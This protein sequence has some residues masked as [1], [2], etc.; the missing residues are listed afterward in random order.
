MIKWSEKLASNTSKPTELTEALIKYSKKLEKQGF[1]VIFDLAHLA[2]ILGIEKLTLASI[3]N[4]SSKFYRSFKIPK[5]RHNTFREI[6]SPYP[7]L[8]K[9][10]DWIKV[11]ILEK[12]EMSHHC[13]SYRKNVSI[14]DNAS[15]HLG[16]EVL[17]KLDLVDFFDNIKED[18]ILS[19]FLNCG[20]SYKVSY[21]LTS[22]CLLTT[23]LPQGAST[24][25]IISNIIAKRLDKRLS[26]LC[27]KY[28]INYS[29]YSDDITISGKFVPP[30]L[31]LIIKNIIAD[32]DF[33]VNQNKEILINGLNKK[34][35]VTG[36]SIT[37]NVLKIPRESKRI[38]KQEVFKFLKY[39]FMI[40]PNEQEFD[41]YFTERLIGKLNY[42]I[43]VEKG[44]EN[45]I[46]LLRSVIEKNKLF[47]SR[48]I[49]EDFNS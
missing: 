46:F 44:N 27:S 32:E 45:P 49:Q 48:I 39:D 26:A 34:K 8:K 18:R 41:P 31:R 19:I 13:Y 23:K 9:I 12:I 14:I 22:L 37:N 36:I 20:Y 6:N 16:N 24:S 21:F 43:N 47:M 30:F 2:L 5:R 28:K 40:N 42:W 33:I 15:V 1:P 4:S 17:Y 29:R 7:V 3:V 38:I 10:Q 11:E 35:I 25:P